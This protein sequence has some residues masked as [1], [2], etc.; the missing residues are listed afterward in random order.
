MP[1]SI[2][3][4]VRGPSG[5]ASAL[6]STGQQPK[7]NPHDTETDPLPSIYEISVPACV[8]PQQQ[9]L[10]P[11]NG[12]W[13]RLVGSVHCRDERILRPV[14]LLP[15]N[16]WPISVSEAAHKRR[17]DLVAGLFPG[18]FGVA[19]RESV[20]RLHELP[21]PRQLR[22]RLQAFLHRSDLRDYPV[23]IRTHMLNKSLEYPVLLGRQPFPGQFVRFIAI[24]PEVEIVDRFGGLARLI[25]QLH[26]SEKG[27]SSPMLV[28]CAMQLL[29][30]A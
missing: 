15:A 14:G 25:S 18:G 9:L 1:R 29:G 20:A 17:S 16:G 11:I 12:R 19:H 10:Q 13:A 3:T 23:G 24:A 27:V 7:I 30:T 21:E 5:T 8:H 22:W 4:A 2:P 28:C 6:K 26:K